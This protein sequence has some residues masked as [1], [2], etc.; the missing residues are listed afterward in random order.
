M[1]GYRTSGINLLMLERIL[2][3]GLY[4]L[5]LAAE[6]AALYLGLRGLYIP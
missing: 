4:S 3:V 5:A 2:E 1:A 6:S